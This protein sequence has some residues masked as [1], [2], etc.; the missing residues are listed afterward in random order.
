MKKNKT[1]ENMDNVRVRY[2]VG[3][4]CPLESSVIHFGEVSVEK[5]KRGVGPP[6]N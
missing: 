6:Q 3:K 1:T 5:K 2:R 4:T